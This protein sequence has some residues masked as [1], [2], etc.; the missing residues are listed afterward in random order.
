[1]AARRAQVARRNGV[2][3]RIELLGHDRGRLVLN[4]EH[5]RAMIASEGSIQ[6]S[7][8]DLEHDR[9]LCAIEECNGCRIKAA[10]RLGIGRSTLYRRMEKLGIPTRKS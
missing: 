7:P 2:P 6:M 1:M 9:I 8:R 4:G 5:A 10:R 3:V